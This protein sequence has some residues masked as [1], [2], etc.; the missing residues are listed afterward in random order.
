MTA[1]S[2]RITLYTI[3]G[4]RPTSVT[5][6]PHSRATTEAT[7]EMATARRNQGVCGKSRLRHQ[8]NPSQSAE[9][10]QH[11]ADPDHRVEGPVQHRVGRRPVVAGTVSRP[12]TCV[13][14]LQPT[15]N[16]S[17]PGIPMPPLTPL[18]VQRP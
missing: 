18:D 8:T 2:V 3:Q 7:P 11:R 10:D 16:E 12:V 17:N 14:V 6:H 13:L 4:W 9:R 1:S 5:I 15:R